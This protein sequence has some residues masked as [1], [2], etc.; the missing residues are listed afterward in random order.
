[1]F[2]HGSRR[3]KRGN[4]GG[5]VGNGRADGEN[6][7]DDEKQHFTE[8]VEM[9]IGKFKKSC[10]NENGGNTTNLIQKRRTVTNRRWSH[11]CLVA[12]GALGARMSPH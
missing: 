6:V 10:R 1:M 3:I 11:I 9:M 7:E 2:P 5:I 12:H 4:D 8:V